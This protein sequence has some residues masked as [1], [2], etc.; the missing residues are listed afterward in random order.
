MRLLPGRKVLEDDFAPLFLAE[1]M[2]G[3]ARMR[4]TG[5]IQPCEAAHIHDRRA[6]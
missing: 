3:Q 6:A 1:L 5:D 2:I 4:H